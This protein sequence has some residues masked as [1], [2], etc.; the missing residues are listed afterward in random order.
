MLCIECSFSDTFC[1]AMN[2]LRHYSIVVN[3]ERSKFVSC[4]RSVVCVCVEVFLVPVYCAC[5]FLRCL[6]FMLALAH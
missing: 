2:N 3:F 5:I 1:V 4:Q 6:Y